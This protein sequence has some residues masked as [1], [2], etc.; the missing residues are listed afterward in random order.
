MAKDRKWLC[1]NE[2]CRALL[3]FIDEK[4]NQVRIKYKDL[5]VTIEGGR[6]ILTCRKCA[7]VNELV[8]Q[9][10]VDYLKKKYSEGSKSAVKQP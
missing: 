10:Y 1:D 6:I 7:K 8:D 4:L 3:G 5:Y 2:N 9:D